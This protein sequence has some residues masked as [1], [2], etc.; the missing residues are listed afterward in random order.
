M[1]DAKIADYGTPRCP[2]CWRSKQF[3]GE[4][5]VP[6]KC[7]DINQHVEGR[8]YVHQVNNGRQIIP[9]ILF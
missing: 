9:A 5:R 1:R 8:S 7:V 4:H 3:L 2:D 6:Y